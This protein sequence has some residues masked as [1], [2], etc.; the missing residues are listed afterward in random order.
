MVRTVVRACR[1]DVAS[2][3]DHDAPQLETR[4]QARRLRIMENDDVARS[5][6]L[7]QHPTVV[8]EYALIVRDF[9]RAEPMSIT[10]GAMQP[11]MD[12]FCDDEELLISFDDHPARSNAAAEG[13]AHKYRQHLGHTAT[14]RR[15]VDVP[16]RTPGQRVAQVASDRN[17]DVRPSA[18]DDGFEPVERHRRYNHITEHHGEILATES[19]RE[20]DIDQSLYGA[21][22]DF[23]VRPI[24]HVLSRVRR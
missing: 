23:W 10:I 1:T 6:A 3:H 2:P 15:G 8:R 22:D 19:E 7:T 14:R 20:M 21:Q 24:G 4:D 17:E 16:H 18:A 5:N 9:V 11:V 12:P 13:V